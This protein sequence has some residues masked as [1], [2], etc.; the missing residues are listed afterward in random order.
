MSNT[1][2]REPHGRES[3]YFCGTEVDLVLFCTRMPLGRDLPYD[4]PFFLLCFSGF[5]GDVRG[6]EEILDRG[7]DRLEQRPLGARDPAGLGTV[8]HL[9]DLSRNLDVHTLLDRCHLPARTG[10]PERQASPEKKREKKK[11]GISHHG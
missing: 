8:H 1:G 5:G 3:N 2:P 7:A 11:K 9:A 6:R 10:F 4:L